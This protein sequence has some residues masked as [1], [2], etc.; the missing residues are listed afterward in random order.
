[1]KKIILFL[2]CILLTFSVNA[3][4]VKLSFKQ[5]SISNAQ[6]ALLYLES[7]VPINSPKLTIEKRNIDF[8][9][10][11]KKEGTYFAF[12]PMD[13]YS[14]LGEH[15]IIV[16]YVKKNKKLFKGISFHLIEG[17][18]K[19]EVLRVAPSKVILSKAN[20]K[21][22]QKEYAQAMEVYNTISTNTFE[23]SFIYPMKTKIT[24][25][26]GTKRTYNGSLKGYHS[27]TDF[28]AQVGTPI[29]ASASGIVRIAQDRFYAGNSV[30]IDHGYGVYSGYYHLSKIGVKVN[31]KVT[32]GEQ[33]GLSGNTGR[34]TGPHLH[35][36]I[37]VHGVQVDPM[38]F[39]EV[40]QQLEG[41]LA[42]KMY[43]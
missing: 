34:V 27:G 14:K 30:V 20:Q 36:S 19:S 37:R 5:Q 40:T 15:R 35:F 9:P 3:Q 23:S 12:I 13:Y 7:S 21:R 39:I 41:K 4:E 25:A 2:Y 11:V 43:E 6:T 26:F 24:S 38:Q 42:N 8:I 16:S 31:Q 18:Y 29:Y 28:K 22:T 10:H 1:M 17:N 32:K 33:I